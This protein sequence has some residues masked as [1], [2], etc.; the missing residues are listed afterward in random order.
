MFSKESREQTA[1][2]SST[3]WSR[4]IYLTQSIDYRLLAYQW[5]QCRTASLVSAESNLAANN[6]ET[7][8]IL[9]AL[10]SFDKFYGIEE[11]TIFWPNSARVCALCRCVSPP[12]VRHLYLLVTGGSQ[13]FSRAIRQLVTLFRT[14][15]HPHRIS[16]HH[17]RIV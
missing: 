7:Q 12:T 15:A 8:H 9:V 17:P 6:R 4:E 11:R 13:L 1:I 5:S 16:I 10:R 14:R 3:M 2:I